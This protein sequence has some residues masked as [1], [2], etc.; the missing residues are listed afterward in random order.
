MS[1]LKVLRWPWPYRFAFSITDDTDG[2]T[3]LTT[4][5]LYAK[6]NAA[7][8]KSTKSVWCIHPSEPCGTAP[9]NAPCEGSSLEDPVYVEALRR[10]HEAGHELGLHGVS[11]GNNT[12]DAVGRGFDAFERLFGSRP[13]VYTC[14]SRNIENPYWGKDLTRLWPMNRIIGLNVRDRFEGHLPTSRYFWL[15]ICQERVDYLRCFRTMRL[16][17]LLKHP[18]KQPDKL[19]CRARHSCLRHNPAETLP[20]IATVAA[21]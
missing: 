15:D 6:L 1:K 3:A 20:R 4:E 19:W 5:I 13:R 11:A 16:N 8:V 18:A 2:A 7:G 21:M 17:T 14:H 9:P 10:V 12:R